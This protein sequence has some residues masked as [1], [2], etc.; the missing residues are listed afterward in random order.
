MEKTPIQFSPRLQTKIDPLLKRRSAIA[1][2]SVPFSSPLLLAPMSSICNAPFRLLMETLGA[3]GTVSELISCHGINYNNVRTKDMLR[4]D[5]R[6]NHVGIQLFGDDPVQMAN[7]AKIAEEYGPKFIDINMGCPV[8]KV[9]GTGAGSSLLKDPS[10]LPLFFSTV[11]KAI[12][13]PLSIKIRIGWDDSSINGKEIIHIA[14]EEGIEFVAVHGRTRA[15]Q[16]TGHARWDVIEDFSK[17]SKT[18]NIPLI[19]NGDLNHSEQIREKL[20][21][22]NTQA[23]MLGRGPL[24]DPFLFLGPYMDEKKYPEDQHIKFLGSD[25]W[26]II[27]LL[28]ELSIPYAHSPQILNVSLR[29]HIMWLSAG[30]NHCG[31]F[32]E[33]LFSIPTIE[34]T[35]KQTKEFFLGHWD[36]EKRIDWNSSFMES[37][38]G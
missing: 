32:R 26:E 31:Q 28:H 29:K 11:K 30:F 2:G 20:A 33:K 37:G 3:G 25:Y 13:I 19:G 10:K 5:P 34:E 23:L 4:I 7:A 8:K 36:S 15:Q 9:V 14:K 21:V 1:L 24:R 12:S 17:V 22:T 18:L 27:E 16:Y 35:L 38:H 6:E